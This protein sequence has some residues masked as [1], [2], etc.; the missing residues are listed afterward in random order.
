[1]ALT[2][3]IATMGFRRADLSRY[4]IRQALRLDRQI[5]RTPLFWKALGINL[6]PGLSQSLLSRRFKINSQD[7]AQAQQV[8][9]SLA[10]IK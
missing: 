8:E 4:Y 2:G 7:Q 1:V 10:A 3:A 6:L 9:K 5:V